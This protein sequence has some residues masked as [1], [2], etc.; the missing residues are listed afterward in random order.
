VNRPKDST[1]SDRDSWGLRVATDQQYQCMG[2]RTVVK[3]VA[4][5][6]PQSVFNRNSRKEY[7]YK[8]VCL[9]SSSLLIEGSVEHYNT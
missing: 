6:S 3:N 5:L 9:F 2:T 8:D 1:L 7:K 4:T